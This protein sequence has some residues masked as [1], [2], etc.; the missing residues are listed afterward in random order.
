[1]YPPGL[2]ATGRAGITGRIAPSVGGQVLAGGRTDLAKREAIMA[3]RTC[4]EGARCI[5]AVGGM[6]ARCI[7]GVGA[8]NRAGLVGRGDA[9]DA[10]VG[11][12]LGLLAGSTAEL[13]GVKD[14]FNP[15]ILAAMAAPGGAGD[16]AV[17]V[18]HA[19]V[20]SHSAMNC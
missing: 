10:T 20:L 2:E 7:T 5:T 15:V 19:L 9:V 18:P 1:M 3:A 12:I 4:G 17:P 14:L 13:P 6:G 11:S 8:R 16:A